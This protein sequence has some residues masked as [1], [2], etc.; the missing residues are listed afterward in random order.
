[1]TTRKETTL[2]LAANPH[3]YEELARQQISETTVRALSALAD[4]LL[5]VRDSKLLKCIDLRPAKR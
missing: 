3:K 1:V 2:V 5:Y 4:G